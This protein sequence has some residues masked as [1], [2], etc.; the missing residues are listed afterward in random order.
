MIGQALD[1]TNRYRDR[2]ENIRDMPISIAITAFLIAICEKNDRGTSP[3]NDRGTS[4][5]IAMGSNTISVLGNQPRC[6]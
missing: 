3:Q 1:I 4:K 2:G 6:F 5:T